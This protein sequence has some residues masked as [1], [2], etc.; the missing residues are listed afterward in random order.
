VRYYFESDIVKLLFQHLDSQIY[1]QDIIV[2]TFRCDTIEAFIEIVLQLNGQREREREE[3][4]EREKVRE[5][6]RESVLLLVAPLSVQKT[7]IAS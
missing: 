6:E 4:G 1:L 7:L 3:E 5:R 2:A